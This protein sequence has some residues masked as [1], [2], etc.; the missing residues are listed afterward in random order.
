MTYF[1]LYIKLKV[2]LLVN[3]ITNII[4]FS[5]SRVLVLLVQL[6][7]I[8]LRHLLNCALLSLNLDAILSFRVIL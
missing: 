4:T 7:D 2:I 5:L 6:Y 3:F 8:V 1:Y